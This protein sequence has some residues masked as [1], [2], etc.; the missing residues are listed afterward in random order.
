[1]VHLRFLVFSQLRKKRATRCTLAIPGF[2]RASA[3]IMETKLT[4]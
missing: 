1:M 3:A 2:F 4:E